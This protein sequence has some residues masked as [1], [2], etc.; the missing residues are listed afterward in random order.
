MTEKFDTEYYDWIHNHLYTAV[1]ADILDSIGFTDQVMKPDMRPL[2]PGACIVGRAATMLASETFTIPKNPYAMELD[3]LDDLKPGEVVVCS[4][5]GHKP[6]AIWG[7]LLSTHS[8]AKGSR[9]AVMAGA[10]RDSRQ[11][12][13]IKFPVF[14]TGLVPADS[15]GRYN[16]VEIRTKTM[17]SGVMVQ[18]GD[19]IIA[20]E[21]GCVVVPELVENDVIQKAMEK[22][23]GE[24]KVREI[25]RSGT[26]IRKVFQDYGIL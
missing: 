3:L 5:V 4:M 23:T 14:C 9:G 25:L 15:K 24:N 22:V 12:T 16:V 1:V 2:Y 7:E 21:D 8:R 26:S 6:A 13:A 10:C 11:I 20:D 19:L 18:N 17:V